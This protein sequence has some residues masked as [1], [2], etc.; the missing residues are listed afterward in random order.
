MGYYVRVFCKS[1]NKPKVKQIIEHVNSLEYT[2]KIETNLTPEEEDTNN[3]TEFELKYK[4][5]KLPLLV[6]FNDLLDSDGLAK[7]EIE[8]FI[9]SIGEPWL[10]GNNKKKII[11]HLRGTR[12]IITNQLPTSDLDDDGY[13]ANGAFFNYFVENYEGM[14]HADGEGFYEG[15]K[16]IFKTK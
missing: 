5:G 8:E 10:F 4:A 16:I 1:E 3:W 7:A 11:N 12:Y 2:F 6:E 14:F 9:E 15:Q 13:D